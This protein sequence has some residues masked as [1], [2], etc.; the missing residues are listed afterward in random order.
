[1]LGILQIIIG[2]Q[3]YNLQKETGWDWWCYAENYMIYSDNAYEIYVDDSCVSIRL[4]YASFM[5]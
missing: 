1:M 4:G 3:T 5:E 2:E